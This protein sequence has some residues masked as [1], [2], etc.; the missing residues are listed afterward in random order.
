MKQIQNS[1]TCWHWQRPGGTCLEMENCLRISLRW[2]IPTSTFSTYQI[3]FQPLRPTLKRSPYAPQ[4]RAWPRTRP[5]LTISRSRQA[6]RPCAPSLLRAP[7]QAILP[8]LS[9]PTFQPCRKRH[10]VSTYLIRP[11]S[12]HSFWEVFHAY[13]LR[14]LTFHLT[15][16]V[17]SLLGLHGSP[18]PSGPEITL[19]VVLTSLVTLAPPRLWAPEGRDCAFPS[20]RLG[21][22]PEQGVQLSLSECLRKEGISQNLSPPLTESQHIA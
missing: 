5:L 15:D 9:G 22:S 14:L 4:P 16:S 8:L 11:H 21:P 2:K 12:H 7:A 17:T 19:Q 6:G 3:E 1:K 10:S 13:M 20:A 18:H